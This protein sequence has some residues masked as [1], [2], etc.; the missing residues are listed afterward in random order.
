M[1]CLKRLVRYDTETEFFLPFQSE[2]NSLSD[3]VLVWIRMEKKNVLSFLKKIPHKGNW[4]GQFSDSS[5]FPT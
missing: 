1:N 4:E 3:N 5:D 2:P